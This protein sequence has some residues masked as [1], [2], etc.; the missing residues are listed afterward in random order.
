MITATIL[1]SDPVQIF[2][3]CLDRAKDEFNTEKVQIDPLC[4]A[5][6]INRT[7]GNYRIAAAMLGCSVTEIKN[8]LQSVR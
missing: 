8:S 1:C 5:R 4:A 2:L 3:E 6:V 7:N